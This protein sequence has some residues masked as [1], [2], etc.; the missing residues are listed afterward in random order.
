MKIGDL[1][2][3]S[4]YGVIRE[5]NGAITRA[6]PAQIGLVISLNHRSDY[7]FNVL[8]SKADFRGRRHNHSRRE[9]KHAKPNT[10]KNKMRVPL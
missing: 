2:C 3:L 5:Y 7:P 8:W 4:K 9:L 6:D 1:V 10:N